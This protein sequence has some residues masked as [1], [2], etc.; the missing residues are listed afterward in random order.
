MTRENEWPR[1]TGIGKTTID[2]RPTQPLRSNVQSKLRAS[3]TA[4]LSVI[5]SLSSDLTIT[6]QKK[7]PRDDQPQPRLIPRSFRSHHACKTCDANI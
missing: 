1:P 7:T 4:D 2:G 5:I 3:Q 6:P